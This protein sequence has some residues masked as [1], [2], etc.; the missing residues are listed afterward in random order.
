VLA[1]SIAEEISGEVAKNAFDRGIGNRQSIIA[2]ESLLKSKIEMEL[3]EEFYEIA[4]ENARTGLSTFGRHTE[5]PQEEILKSIKNVIRKIGS[6]KDVLEEYY[7]NRKAFSYEFLEGE[8]EE[9][10]EKKFTD[11]AVE[12]LR[13]RVKLNTDDAAIQKISEKLQSQNLKQ[14]KVDEEIIKEIEIKLKKGFNVKELPDEL[15]GVLKQEVDSLVN[16]IEDS[17]KIPDS[18]IKV[19]EYDKLVE[20][21]IKRINTQTDRYILEN[22]EKLR[23]I[24]EESFEE[25][26]KQWIKSQHAKTLDAEKVIKKAKPGWRQFFIGAR[27]LLKEGAFGA[28]ANFVGMKFY[29]LS[30]EKSLKNTPLSREEE[31]KKSGIDVSMLTIEGESG[32]TQEIINYRTYKITI[33]QTAE[34]KKIV[35]SEPTI[36]PEGT[37]VEQVLNECNNQNIN[38][39]IATV[40]PGLLPDAHNPP[41]TMISKNIEIKHASIVLNYLKKQESGERIGVIIAEA[42]KD[43]KANFK[44][45]TGLDLEAMVVSLGVVKSGLGI[46]KT[47]K[48]MFGCNFQ[49]KIKEEE[50]IYNN[51]IC[52]KK[53][54]IS[55]AQECKSDAGCYFSKYN[56]D[57]DNQN[58]N[59]ITINNP[60]EFENIYQKWASYAWN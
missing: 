4:R 10:L 36:I 38:N 44:K 29:E 9:A 43:E 6:D 17:R 12:E 48:Y 16:L 40:L 35:I 59:Y 56:E 25:K 14:S 8:E 37:S 39:E 26:Y 18:S 33:T 32:G 54:L 28:L 23:G 49:K 31:L 20:N 52:A 19:N 45:E 42:I 34:E 3:S 30:L 51:A 60:K 50:N 21:M 41:T 22:P 13:E 57:K 53:K 7:K 55:Y 58:S 1:K 46:D 24:L 2:L 15:K 11:E 27:T 5:I 47:N